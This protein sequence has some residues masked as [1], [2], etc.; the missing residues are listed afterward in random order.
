VKPAPRV[1]TVSS[2]DTIVLAV[3][4]EGAEREMDLGGDIKPQTGK[5]RRMSSGH[6]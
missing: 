5:V 1:C 2:E 3:I 4:V 6:Q